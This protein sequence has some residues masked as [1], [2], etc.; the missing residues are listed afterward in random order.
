MIT[1]VLSSREKTKALKT[2]GVWAFHGAKDPVVRSKNPTNGGCLEEGWCERSEF[3]I[4]PDAGHNSWT[5]AYNDPQLYEW[6]L[7]HETH[8]ESLRFRAR[9]HSLNPVISNRVACH[10]SCSETCWPNLEPWR[11]QRS[12]LLHVIRI[13]CQLCAIGTRLGK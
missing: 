5:E 7:K 8:C 11:R 3:T 13:R 2:L 9:A 12:S 4:Y 10:S 1:V 6:L